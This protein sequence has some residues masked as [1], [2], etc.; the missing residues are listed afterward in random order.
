MREF[1]DEVRGD[2][3]VILRDCPPS[4]TLAS[5]SAM[6]AADGCLVPVISAC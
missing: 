4:L 1:V 3:G 5:W 2:Y 6:V